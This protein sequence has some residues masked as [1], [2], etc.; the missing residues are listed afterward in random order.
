MD[1]NSTAQVRSAAPKLDGLYEIEAFQEAN[2]H[3]WPSLHSLR[4]F[5]R[6]Q[7]RQLI[8]EQALV[9]IAGRHMIHGQNFLSA[10]VKIGTQ[11][12]AGR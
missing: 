2:A 8:E 12:A 10:L 1:T 9:L 6:M 3:L 4:W 7:K 11:A 5:I